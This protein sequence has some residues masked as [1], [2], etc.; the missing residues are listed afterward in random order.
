MN[1]KKIKP[2]SCIEHDFLLEKAKSVGLKEHGIL[3]NVIK[4]MCGEA[5]DRLLREEKS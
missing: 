5:V 2:F 1:M 3:E 4:E